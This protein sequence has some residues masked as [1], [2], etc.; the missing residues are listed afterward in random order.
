MLTYRLAS[1][2]DAPQLARLRWLHEWEQDSNQPMAEA[3]FLPLCGAFLAKALEEKSY[4]CFLAE[5]EGKIISNVWVCRVPKIPSPR[6]A[7]GQIGYVT[8]VHTLR[9]YRSR[10]IG[11]ALMERVKAFAKENGYELLFVWPSG[12][13]VPFY[14]RQGF[15]AENEMMECPLACE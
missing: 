8:N 13:A 5:E 7:Q 1:P 9:Q 4:F 2:A 3:Q 14:E 11:S 12:R 15:C 10:G 6:E